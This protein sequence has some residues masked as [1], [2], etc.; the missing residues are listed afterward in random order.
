MIATLG[1]GGGGQQI[2]AEFTAV[3]FLASLTSG[4]RFELNQSRAIAGTEIQHQNSG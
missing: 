2:E 3:S 4:L 1:M